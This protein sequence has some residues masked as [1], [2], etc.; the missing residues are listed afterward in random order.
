MVGRC[1]CLRQSE[2]LPFCRPP[3]SLSG[4]VLA[5][6]GPWDFVILA[7]V[8][9]LFFGSKRIARALRA[10]RAGGRELK[11]GLRGEDELPPPKS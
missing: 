9:A 7:I 2:R 10:L 3:S 8:I 4:A 1:N 6:L 5:L 11:R